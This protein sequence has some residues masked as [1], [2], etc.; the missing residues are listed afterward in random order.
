M[1]S[2]KLFLIIIIAFILAIIVISFSSCYN[3]KKATAQFSKAAINY[4]IIPAEYCAVTFP[5]KEKLI[6][7]DSV[8]VT[9]TLYM[10]DGVV[11]DTLTTKDTVYI[12]KTE[13]KTKVVTNTITRTDTIR[14][15]DQA[16]VKAIT[17]KRDEIQSLLV[18]KT[19]EYDKVKKNRDWWRIV[20]ICCMAVIGLGLLFKLRSVFNVSK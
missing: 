7:G 5:P 17:I 2:R 10:A 20:A 12:T 19:N 13:V 4:P 16:Q 15:T 3:Q 8:L 14:Q 6:K 1:N 18:K 9:D 11:T